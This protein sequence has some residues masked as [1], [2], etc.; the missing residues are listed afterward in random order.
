M[1]ERLKGAGN[2]HEGKERGEGGNKWQ[3]RWSK[4]SRALVED[5]LFRLYT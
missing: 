1:E 3:V 2:E 5:Y 4:M